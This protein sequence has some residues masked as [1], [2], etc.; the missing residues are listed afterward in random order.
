VVR[1]DLGTGCSTGAAEGNVQETCE[2]Q[3]ALLEPPMSQTKGHETSRYSNHNASG[4][5]RPSI[6]T[7]KHK[8]MECGTEII[9]DRSCD[10]CGVKGH[11]TTTC[12]LNPKRSHVVERKGM[13]RGTRG[14]RGRPRMRRCNFEDSN[15]D[16]CEDVS[17]T[18]DDD[19][20]GDE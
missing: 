11:Y 19:Y 16:P 6:S 4:A 17:F 10:T 13:S 12:P 9:G 7:Y 18:E 14:K 15:D 2:N 8:R 20:S 3:I 5:K 1:V